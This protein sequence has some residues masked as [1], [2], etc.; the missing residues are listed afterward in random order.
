MLVRDRVADRKFV[1]G[2]PYEW[3]TDPI[4]NGV[5]GLMGTLE[6]SI[7]EIFPYAK[8][9]C[10]FVAS[11]SIG[12][13]IEIRWGIPAPHGHLEPFKVL[14]N[15]IIP[16]IFS[17]KPFSSSASSFISFMPFVSILSFIPGS[18]PHLPAP[19]WLF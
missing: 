18:P 15:P 7:R 10:D 14:Y 6:N 4:H 3:R 19:H 1:G 8:S 17:M 2:L 13:P 11:F 12:G 9:K 16:M 5:S